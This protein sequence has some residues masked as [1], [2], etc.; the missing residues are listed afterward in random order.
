MFSNRMVVIVGLIVFFAVSIIILTVTSRVSQKSYGLDSTGIAVVGPFQDGSTWFIRSV[1]DI[2]RH[3]FRLVSVAEENERLH[4]QIA[5]SE[6]LNNKLKEMTLANQRLRNLL[7]FR[8]NIGQE[9]LSAEIIGKDPSPWFKTV[10]IDKGRADGLDIG[11]PVVVPEGIVGQ[12][13]EVASHYAKVLLIIDQNNAVDGLVQRTRA[14]GIIKGSPNGQ[15]KFHYTLR[16]Y[17]V[18][19][20]DT[21][22]SSGLD[23]VFPKGL[24][25][26]GVSAVVKRHSGIFQEVAVTPFVD[27]ETLEE[28]MVILNVQPKPHDMYP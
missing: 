10:I 14:R 12:I 5:E 6:A 9:I 21:I 25:V 7:N 16:K 15:C 17:D 27:F 13:A 23:G 2:W 1:K 26:G 22:I 11:Y 28:V 8:K 4:K 20:G 24:R 19:V 3:Y 18:R